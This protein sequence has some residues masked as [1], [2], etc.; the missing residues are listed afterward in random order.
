MMPH[1]DP[2]ARRAYL[3]AY[4]TAHREEAAARQR[5]RRETNREGFRAYRRAWYAANRERENARRAELRRV[6]ND[7]MVSLAGERVYIPYLPIEVRPIAFLIKEAR[8]EIRRR[9]RGE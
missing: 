2:E 8:R 6:R 5:K 9:T 1:T 4:H 3:A 7:S